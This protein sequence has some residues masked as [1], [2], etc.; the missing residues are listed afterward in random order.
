MNKHKARNQNKD[1]HRSCFRPTNEKQWRQ[2]TKPWHDMH[3]KLLCI[4]TLV[5]FRETFMRRNLWHVWLCGCSWHHTVLSTRRHPTVNPTVSARTWFFILEIQALRS[6]HN[7]R[8]RQCY[9]LHDR[10]NSRD[11]KAIRWHIIN[12]Q[13]HP[14][15]TGPKAVDTRRI[16]LLQKYPW[17]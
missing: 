16:S 11:N 7:L 1:Y 12:H 4:Y 17:K 6:G 5:V 3:H 9:V 8:G 14:N 2:H 10:T 13:L 15:G